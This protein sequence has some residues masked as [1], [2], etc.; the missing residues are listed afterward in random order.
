MAA[1][2]VHTDYDKY[3]RYPQDTSSLALARTTEKQ[4]FI[5]VPETSD[6][7][8]APAEVISEDGG[9]LAVRLANGEERKIQGTADTLPRKNPTKF[10]GV[11][12]MSNLSHLNEPSVL[13]NLKKRYDC[14]LF[15]VCSC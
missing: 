5:W 14:N 4:T 9:S 7:G 2:Q 1:T 11:E 10:D 15:Y 13:Y 6:F 12:D 8:F 3:L